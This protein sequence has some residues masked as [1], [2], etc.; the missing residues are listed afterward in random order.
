[1][2]SF[3]PTDESVLLRLLNLP[4]LLADSALL[5]RLTADDAHADIAVLV[6]AAQ[7]YFSAAVFSRTSFFAAAGRGRPKSTHE[8]LVTVDCRLRGEKYRLAVQRVSPGRYR[9]EVEGKVLTIAIDTVSECESRV[10][11]GD[12]SHRVVSVTQGKDQLIE[13]DNVI[14]RIGR[15]D[16]GMVRSPSPSLVVAVR[17][18]P[19]DL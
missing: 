18:K 19:G 9:F 6:A 17:V 12:R 16:V 13:V 10:T 2:K 8:S 1:M 14:H 11:V 4:E 15:G 7:A 3:K 5:D